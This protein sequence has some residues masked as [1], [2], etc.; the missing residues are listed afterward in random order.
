MTRSLIH[1]VGNVTSY[2]TLLMLLLERPHQNILFRLIVRNRIKCSSE[3]NTTTLQIHFLLCFV[4]LNLAYL[5]KL[6]YLV[7]RKLSKLIDCLVM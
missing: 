7:A 3:Q 4:Y 6:L 5:N 1:Y 2:I